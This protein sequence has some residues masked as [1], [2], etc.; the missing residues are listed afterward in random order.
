VNYDVASQEAHLLIQINPLVNWIW[1]GVGIMII[2]TFV[3][4][5]PERAFAF[6]RSHVPESAATTTSTLVLLLVLTAGATTA[7]AQHIESAQPIT[8]IARSP[9]EKD[10]HEHVVCM[11]GTCGRRRIGECTCSYAADMRAEIAQLVAD[12]K[13]REEI[14]QYLVRE[15][16][17]QEV[18]AE[19]IDRGFNRLAWLLPYGAGLAGIVLVGGMAVR[20]SR[21]RPVDG[22][23]PAVA[24]AAR[25]DLEDRLDD[26]LR[27]LD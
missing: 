4:F 9:L 22:T 2:G 8:V 21:R 17:S 23:E 24:A 15:Y 10:L 19:P 5:L 26:E 25:P 16:G 1:F 13:T 6:A 27:E 12:G 14:V 18:L 20:W 11:C 7:R 3:A